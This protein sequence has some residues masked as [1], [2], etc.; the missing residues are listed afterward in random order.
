MSRITDG[1]GRNTGTYAKHYQMQRNWLFDI[2]PYTRSGPQ[3]FDDVA[4]DQ[5][6]K[7]ALRRSVTKI[8]APQ[9]LIDTIRREVRK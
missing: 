3:S 7:R 6:L 1:N 8:T 2:E 4:D 5:R 9:Y